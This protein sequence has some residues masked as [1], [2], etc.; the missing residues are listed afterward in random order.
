[1]KQVSGFSLCFDYAPRW[2][3][4]CMFAS[5]LACHVSSGETPVPIEPVP[6]RVAGDSRSQPEKATAGT[7]SAPGTASES[8]VAATKR[9]KSTVAGGSSARVE[10]VA[11]PIMLPEIELP[12]EP[13]VALRPLLS[14][15]TKKKRDRHCVQIRSLQDLKVASRL[16]SEIETQLNLPTWIFSADLGAKGNWYRLCVGADRSRKAAEKNAALWTAG[17]GLL[18]PY[19]DT[20]KEGDARYLLKERPAP[21]KDEVTR[22]QAEILLRAGVSA[23]SKVV[24]I[25]GAKDTRYAAM[26][27]PV[28]PT[29]PDQTEVLVVSPAGLML[30]VAGAPD[31]RCSACARVWESP[32]VSRRILQTGLVDEV[33]GQV[34][35]IT[36]SVG[37][38]NERTEVLSVLVPEA[39]RLTR[40]ASFLLST[41]NA[42]LHVLGHAKWLQG[43]EDKKNELALV[44][45][46]LSLVEDRL[47]ALRMSSE[48]YD[49]AEANL[50][51]LD[52]N[53]IAGL[54]TSNARDAAGTALRLIKGYDGLG[55]VDTSS[56]LC[57]AYL[58]NG[59]SPKVARHCLRRVQQLST[60]SVL[61]A[62][63]A[64]GFLAEASSVYRAAV[65][66]TLYRNALKLDRNEALRVEAPNC[67]ENP[68]VD[69]IANKS[70]EELVRLAELKSSSQLNL[71]ELPDAVFVAGLRD[72]GAETPFGALTQSW[73]NRIRDVLPARYAAIQAALLPADFAT[74]AQVASSE[75]G[76]ALQSDGPL[77]VPPENTPP[78]VQAEN[79]VTP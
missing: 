73:L 77:L 75:T 78:S 43:D 5:Q 25:E 56:R 9:L 12:A 21:Q 2:L 63:K 79:E 65:A 67:M 48:I 61:L 44:R 53:Y 20:V 74:R 34:L 31:R 33:E 36:E 1:M 59:R 22:A 8:D 28:N 29:V 18:H 40:R 24:I 10:P 41:R 11:A 39:D 71:A 7:D 45:F 46:E 38:N 58:A 52:E 14:L 32:N 62:T 76:P 27:V 19:M 47:C 57:A 60:K 68:L 64:A 55:D 13:V 37:D 23:E 17:D 42:E 49:F 30:P 4:L 51:K 3:V 70:D 6:N 26:T 54:A 69:D 35:L 16:A 15:R 72:F 66:N 50:T